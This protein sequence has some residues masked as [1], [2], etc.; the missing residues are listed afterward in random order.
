M[1]INT[2]IINSAITILKAK[3]L[4]FRVGGKREK[5]LSLNFHSRKSIDI[6]YNGRWGGE[7]LPNMLFRNIK[8]DTR[9]SSQRS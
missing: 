5:R 2:D 1:S 7:K 4:E 9:R 3:V 6:T 8:V